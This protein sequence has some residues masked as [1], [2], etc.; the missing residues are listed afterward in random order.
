MYVVLGNVVKRVNALSVHFHRVC[1]V[2]VNGT[3]LDLVHFIEFGLESDK[4]FALLRFKINKFILKLF[5][6]VSHL[7]EVV[8]GQEEIKILL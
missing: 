6:R 2:L 8:L 7:E 3:V 1:L 5:K 4:I